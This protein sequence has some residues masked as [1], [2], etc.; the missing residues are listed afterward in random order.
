[1]IVSRNKKNHVNLRKEKYIYKELVYSA[2]QVFECLVITRMSFFCPDLII[3]YIR[4]KMLWVIIKALTKTLTF[5]NRELLLL[6]F[7]FFVF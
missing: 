1:M 7:F 3:W 5:S 4:L 2:K 6:F